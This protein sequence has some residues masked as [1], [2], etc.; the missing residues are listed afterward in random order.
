MIGI[1]RSSEIPINIDFIQVLTLTS[2]SLMI[3][4]LL[5]STK[6]WASPNTS[7]IGKMKE[8]RVA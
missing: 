1:Y 7:Y 2:V 6:V 8:L 4:M 5:E 3:C